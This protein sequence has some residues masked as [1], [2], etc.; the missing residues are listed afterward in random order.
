MEPEKR[1]DARERYRRALRLPTEGGIEPKIALEAMFSVP[2]FF[3]SDILMGSDPV[4]Q[5]R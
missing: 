4:M 5:F 2:R 1:L 3:S